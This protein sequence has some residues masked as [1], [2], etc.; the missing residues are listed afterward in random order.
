MKKQN[1]L[2]IVIVQ[3]IITFTLIIYAFISLIDSFR[4]FSSS[5]NNFIAL[6]Y[7]IQLLCF[8]Y[9]SLQIYQMN[10]PRRQ[11]FS[12]SL[13][14]ALLNLSINY[15]IILPT[16]FNTFNIIILNPTILGKI[17]NFTILNALLLF[18]LCGI[19]QNRT[20]PKNQNYIIIM[21]FLLSLFLTYSIPV[22]SPT[23]S[24]KLLF[25][26]AKP[27]FN[28]IYI[29]FII[30]GMLSYIPS[31]IQDK[32]KHNRL[33]TISFILLVLSIGVLNYSNNL[34]ILFTL[35]A[36]FVLIF[37]SIFLVINLKSYSI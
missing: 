13:L 1:Q 9:I 36:L 11:V 12:I 3:F 5:Y 15:L 21:T 17:H 16:F 24:N 28:Y 7:L 33:K 29:L 31:F 19:N 10:E 23:M 37:S 20:N 14:F 27:L 4:F 34:N 8:S 6:S 35:I 30:L 32:S 18:I 22:N 26:E 2:I 25:F